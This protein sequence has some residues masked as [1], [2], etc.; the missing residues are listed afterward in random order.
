MWKEGEGKG[1]CYVMPSLYRRIGCHISGVSQC[2]AETCS[3]CCGVLQQCGAV[4]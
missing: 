1:L 2:V 4:M 3:V